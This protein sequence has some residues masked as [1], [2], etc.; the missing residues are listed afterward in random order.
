[1][2]NPGTLQVDTTSLSS[3]GSRLAGEFLGIGEL[4]LSD[5]QLPHSESDFSRQHFN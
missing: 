5:G 3:L 1:M 4:T 2:K